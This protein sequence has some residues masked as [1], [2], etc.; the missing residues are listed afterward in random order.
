MYLSQKTGVILG[1]LFSEVVRPNGCSRVATK[2]LQGPG[3]MNSEKIMMMMMMVMVMVMMM[4]VMMMM[5]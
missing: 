1:P 5:T 3:M 2:F 4:M